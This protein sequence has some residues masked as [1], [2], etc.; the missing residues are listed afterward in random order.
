MKKMVKAALAAV[1]VCFSSSLFA[2]EPESFLKGTTF[3]LFEDEV[4][5]NLAWGVEDTTGLVLGGFNSS[6]FNFNIGTGAWLGDFWWSLY[7]T[8]RF[9]TDNTT[10]T[11]SV[12]ND[13]VAKDGINT[14]YT[15]VDTS[16]TKNRAAA[17]NLK[18][19][20]FV[21]FSTGDWGIQS[22]WKIND[23][24]PAGDYGKKTSTTE[25][26]AAGTSATEE[27][28]IGRYNGTNTFGVNFNGIGASE[29]G[30]VD[31]YFQLNNFELAWTKNTNNTEFSKT[32]K[33]N[34]ATYTGGSYPIWQ[35]STPVDYNTLKDINKNSTNTFK[36]SISGEMG[37]SLPD[38]GSMT[39]AFILGEKF[40]ATLEAP[41]SDR[42]VNY[43]EENFNEKITTKITQKS[44]EK[45]RFSW[46]NT[47]TPKF[48]FDFDVG[49]R[50]S[51]KASAG[52]DITISGNTNNKAYTGTTI[53]EETTYNKI[54][55]LT[56]KDYY[57]SVNNWSG[58]NQLPKVFTTKLSPETALALV[59]QVKPEKFNL[60]L[61][62][63]W[64]AGTYTWTTTKNTKQPVKQ[65]SYG[66]I[67]DEAGNKTVYTDSVNWVNRGDGTG[68]NDATAETKV[69]SFV[70]T[71]AAAPVLK[72]GVT[73]FITENATLDIAYTNGGFTNLT[74]WNGLMNSNLKLM[75][76]VKF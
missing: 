52:T 21:S 68:A 69:T 48:I 18:N 40:T 30:D 17:K 9:I 25:D 15:D 64:K 4:V 51:I 42:T 16:S 32:Y 56:S 14:D 45:M 10:K 74:L 41:K 66:E 65:T 58:G 38:L 7:D 53:Q 6:N 22:Y 70:A 67:T 33:Q 60:N 72:L 24:T 13:V 3:G 71:A 8:G 5:D 75:F 76:S 37:L 29:I 59:Y 49:E 36:P 35:G 57:K 73:W 43:V 61:G 26:H 23:T 55:K 27:Q 1:L 12:T 54:T 2:A 34:G 46:E 47:F 62:V 31:L 44:N 19:D 20:L 39:T 11:E 63:N 50:L 28:K